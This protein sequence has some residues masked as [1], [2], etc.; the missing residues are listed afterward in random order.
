MISSLF[1]A[2][3]ENRAPMHLVFGPVFTLPPGF[4]NILATNNASASFVQRRE[5]LVCRIYR[6]LAFAPAKAARRPIEG[7]YYER[8]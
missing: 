6:A 3:I 7:Q 2:Q 4:K 5:F 1:G 8:K